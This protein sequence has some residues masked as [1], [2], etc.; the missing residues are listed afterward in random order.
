ME[1]ND[2]ILQKYVTIIFD[3]LDGVNR[4][5]SNGRNF[6]R[7][8]SERTIF[9]A[10]LQTLSLAVKQF[11]GLSNLNISDSHVWLLVLKESF[12]RYN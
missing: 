11:Q 5:P 9:T 10:N 8:P 1:E 3:R 2:C 7:Q 4:R 12:Y 6:S